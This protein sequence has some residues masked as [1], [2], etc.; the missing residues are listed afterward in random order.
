MNK[1]YVAI[2]AI[3]VIGG[4][5]LVGCSTGSK[6]GGTDTR[7]GSYHY[8]VSGVV[9]AAQVDME[10]GE[11]FALD[12]VAYGSGKGGGGGS[13]KKDED[14]GSS[15]SDTSSVELGQGK[16]SA[17]PV[18]R[19]PSVAPE[20]NAKVPSVAPE[21]RHKTFSKLGVE[22]KQKPDA[23][24][25]VRKVPSVKTSKKAKGCKPE[26]ELFVRNTSGLFEQDVREVDWRMCSD[27]PREH[28]PLCT[29]N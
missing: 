3:T 8:Q 26:Y 14:S 6:E 20:R 5:G 11:D 25:R 24:E 17:P 21:K 16:S 1:K 4:A 12:L 13:K 27:R 10:C 9:E 22:L 18:K 29:D 7:A 15:L 2:I 28:F 19:I 23:P